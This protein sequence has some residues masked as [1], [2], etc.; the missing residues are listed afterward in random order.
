VLTQFNFVIEEHDREAISHSRC[1]DGAFDCVCLYRQQPISFDDPQARIFH[2]CPRI[3]YST[4]TVGRG[5]W[6]IG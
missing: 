4:G 6:K 5:G 2:F 3:N 1:G